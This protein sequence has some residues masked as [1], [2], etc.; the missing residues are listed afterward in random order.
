[1]LDPGLLALER[2]PARMDRRPLLN[3]APGLRLGAAPLEAARSPLGD[4]PRPLAP[5]LRFERSRCGR[6]GSRAGRRRLRRAGLHA[7]RGWDG[8]EE[9]A[10]AARGALDPDASP[11]GLDDA[12]DDGQAEPCPPPLGLARLPEAV[13]QV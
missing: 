2:P 12:L 8:E 3:A 9:G 6:P 4:G 11:V 10:A 5:S 13:E 1:G 7:R